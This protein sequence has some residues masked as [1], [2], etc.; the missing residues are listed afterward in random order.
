MSGDVLVHT[1][2]LILECLTGV[3]AL[4]GQHILESLLLRPQ[5]LHLLLMSVQL[6]VEGAAQLHQVVQ[7][8]LKVRCV[9]RAALH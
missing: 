1:V 3:L 2:K 6:L 8:A 9:I 7:L 5:D 4:H